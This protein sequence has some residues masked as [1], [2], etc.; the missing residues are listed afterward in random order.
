[1]KLTISTLCFLLF[2]SFSSSFNAQN[3]VYGTF[4]FD[5]ESSAMV[6]TAKIGDHWHLYSQKT[7]PSVGPVP[8]SFAYSKNK[9]IKVEGEVSEP[10]PIEH[11]DVNFEGDV[12][13]FE[14]TVELTQKIKFKKSTTVAGTISYM[15]CNDEMCLP[16]VDVP[17]KIEVSK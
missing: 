1:M 13:F 6:F 16:P 2:F 11:Y 9:S 8:T 7:D 14:G 5:R 17:F 12:L 10:K 4:D 15:V 3:N